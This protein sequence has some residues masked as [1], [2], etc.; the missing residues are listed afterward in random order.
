MN[1]PGIRYYYLYDT[2]P[3]LNNNLNR[4]GRVF[5][6]Q[7]TIVFDDEEIV[8]ALSYKSNRNWTLPAPKLG[9]LTPNICGDESGTSTGVL[10]NSSEYMYVTYRFRDT[11][12]FGQG[13]D[14]LHCN[15]YT[16]IQGPTGSTTDSNVTI[17]FGSEFP[18]LIQGGLNGFSA[19]EMYM[20][21]QV[22]TGD[23]RPSPTN[24]KIIDVTSQ[25]Q[26]T[27]VNG[28][29]TE[30]GLTSNTF[31]I[32]TD[33][34]NSQTSG[35]T[36]S[37]YM[38]IP[39]N[40]EDSLLNFGDEF[41][42]YGSIET[43]IQATIHEMRYLIN[44]SRNQF[45]NTSNPTYTSGSTAYVSEIGLYDRDKDL[46]VVSKLQSP[47]IRQGIQQYVVKLDF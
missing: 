13:Q 17:R 47:E 26:S 41:F 11:T 37:N 46:I 29:I 14:T 34:Y 4:V 15:Y 2:H 19:D 39:Y 7:Q 9:L 28:Y 23:T 18:Y 45:T 25:L 24:W 21:C 44:L 27:M 43:D 3:D 22:V 38:S 31:V 35:Y 6:D 10:T 36:L 16:K 42:F 12:R 8:A 1:D 5:P 20:L 40:G 30:A 33:N 32:N